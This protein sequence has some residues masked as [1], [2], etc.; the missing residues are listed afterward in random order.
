MFFQRFLY[1]VL[2]VLLGTI[3]NVQA[4]E[5]DLYN[6]QWLDPDKKVYVLQK[7]VY[8]RKGTFYANFG[9][10]SGLNFNYLDVSGFL[11][12][13]GYYFGEEWAFEVF[14]H[15]YRNGANEAQKNILKTH[16]EAVPF[17]R[18]FQSKE[19]GMIL[20]SPFYGKINTFN[21]IIYF[22]WSF[23][24]GGGTLAAKSNACCVAREDSDLDKFEAE[25]FKALFFKTAFRIY[26]NK[27]LSV[28]AEYHR[29]WY[30]GGGPEFIEGKKPKKD[31]RFY[32]EFIFLM[33]LSF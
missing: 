28:G 12:G 3:S 24:L 16:D 19:G 4:S 33:G 21:K 15:L 10:L 27:W 26:M 14:Y 11:A 17:I 20:W 7:K 2:A 31:L 18:K 6:F 13:I 29:N 22:D 1:C 8:K 5:K 23:G 30:N 25:S 9:Y 32:G